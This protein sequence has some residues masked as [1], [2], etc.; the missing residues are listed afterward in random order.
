MAF[1]EFRDVSYLALAL[2]SERSSAIGDALAKQAKTGSKSSFL[3][4]NLGKCV[5]EGR[6]SELDS[7]LVEHFDEHWR[8]I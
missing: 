6:C 4:E 2:L 8:D 1:D 5:F 7:S 3:L